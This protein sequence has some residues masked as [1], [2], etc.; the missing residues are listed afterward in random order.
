M[1][2]AFSFAAVLI[3]C[4]FF[5]SAPTSSQHLPWL[6]SLRDECRQVRR[7]LLAVASGGRKCCVYCFGGSMERASC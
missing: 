5:G 7:W 3:L 4:R 1:W 2:L 6:P